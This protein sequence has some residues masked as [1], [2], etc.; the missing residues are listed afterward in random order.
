MKHLHLTDA[1]QLEI[2][3]LGKKYNIPKTILETYAIE[4]SRRIAAE[5]W[6]KENGDT[7]VIRDSR[8]VPKNIIQA[9]QLKI[10][11]DA[12]KICTKIEEEYE[13]R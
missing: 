8:G 13:L 10:A 3:R 2:T 7:I 12:A 5:K 6:L 4:Q 11:R 9:P 1:Q